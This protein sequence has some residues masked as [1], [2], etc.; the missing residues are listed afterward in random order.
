MF[1]VAVFG[2]SFVM[3]AAGAIY[4]ASRFYR[5]WLM[6]KLAKGKKVYRIAASV[7]TVLLLLLVTGKALGPI[8]AV[9][10]LLHLAVFWLL[11]DFFFWLL[12]LTGK[13][14]SKYYYAGAL[15]ILVSVAYL[16]AGW[17]MAHHVWR[18]DYLVIT[19]KIEGDLRV[20]QVADAHIGTTFSGADFA[21]YVEEIQALEPGLVLIT[22]DFVDDSTSQADMVAACEALGRLNTT[23]GVYFAFGNHDKGYYGPDIRGYNG[24]GLIGE[25][26]KN[27][28]QVLQD[29]TLLIDGRF[30]LIGRKDFS[31]ERGQQGARASM[32]QLTQGLDPEKFSIVMDHQPCDYQAQENAGVDLVLSGHTHGGQLIPIGLINPL[33]SENDKVYG[34]EKRGDTN[35][36]VSSGISDWEVLFKTGCRSE[37]VVIEVKGK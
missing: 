30:Y 28:V 26:E 9:V 29:E 13:G 27:R 4:L 1:W 19:D 37:Y 35:F 24:N 22:G 3:A 18:T 6:G 8:N 31:E 15:A 33:V 5:F 14:P 12:A 36:I 11:C 17:V 23:Y 32:D 25:L 10:C 7:F 34:H 2:L 20:V 16:G 21:R